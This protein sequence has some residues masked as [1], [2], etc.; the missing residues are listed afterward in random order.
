MNVFEPIFE[1]EKGA[2][3]YQETNNEKMMPFEPTMEERAFLYQQVQDL[4]PLASQF[5]SMTV[6]VE[7]AHP[8]NEPENKTFGVTFVVAPENM[9][10]RVRG[11]GKNLYETCIVAKQ[12]T[13]TRLNEM[14]NQVPDAVL[15]AARA[16]NPQVPP[17]Q[18]H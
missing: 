16:E 8:A 13:Q 12:E 6:L 14:I 2:Y 15:Q 4:E 17:D 5:G 9:E 7:E 18:L 10:F 11:E 3:M 1:P